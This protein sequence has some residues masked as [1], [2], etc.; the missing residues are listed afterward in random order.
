LFLLSPAS[1]HGRRAQILLNPDAAF[2]LATRLREPNRVTL[3]EAFSFLSGLYFR[4]KLTYA[5]AFARWT[6]RDSGIRVIT[7][8]RGLLPAN[9]PIT[10]ADLQGFTSVPVDPREPSYRDPLLRDAAAI[11]ATLA[12][13]DEV[14]L[15]GSVATEKYCGPLSEV[16][17][18]RLRFPAEFIGRGDM[19]RGG[20]MLRCV[21][22]QQELTYIP[23]AGATRRGSRPSKLPKRVST[24]AEDELPQSTQSSQRKE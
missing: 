22:E 11:A 15:L 24:K 5:S 8:G 2:D 12:P 3:G 4:G 16:F 20:L 17:G 10:A 6:N 7:A 21:D 23:L 19:S 1:C 9:T 13:A 18:E 14:V